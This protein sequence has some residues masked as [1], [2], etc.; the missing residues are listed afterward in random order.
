MAY[1]PN[2]PPSSVKYHYG[3][4]FITGKVDG[5]TV[6]SYTPKVDSGA[7]ALSG[8][9]TYKTGGTN[10][11]PYLSFNGTTDILLSAINSGIASA[12]TCFLV[13]RAFGSAGVF[14]DSAVVGARSGLEWKIGAPLDTGL[15]AFTVP[16]GLNSIGDGNGTWSGVGAD[17]I[18]IIQV[19]FDTSGSISINGVSVAA[20]DLTTT[21]LTRISLGASAGNFLA[22][23]HYDLILGVRISA[24]EK[25]DVLAYLF[26]KY[27]VTFASDFA[28]AGKNSGVP[29][30]QQDWQVNTVPSGSSPIS[31]ASIDFSG[32]TV[33]P[34]PLSLTT[35]TGYTTAATPATGT[36]S[37]TSTGGITQ[38][39]PR[40]LAYLLKTQAGIRIFWGNSLTR[41]F[42]ATTIRTTPSYVG[43]DYPSDVYRA[44]TKDTLFWY[45]RGVDSRTTTQMLSDYSALGSPTIQALVQAAVA[46]GQTVELIVWEGGN[47]LYLS[48]A[49]NAAAA[50]ANLVALKA[51][52]IADA[53]TATVWVCTVPDRADGGN[54]NSTTR[55]A[56]NAL[57]V[58]GQPKVIRYDNLG[59]VKTD[60][61]YYSTDQ[62]HFND[63]GYAVIAAAAS[64]AIDPT[65]PPPTLP[66]TGWIDIN[67]RQFHGF[68]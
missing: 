6:V 52:I 56:L 43:T 46:A 55:S 15:G 26:T 18:R 47:D 23:H 12:F 32:E 64:A 49:A 14:F 57:I 40:T 61:T 24:G 65:T 28:L 31:A 33:T 48:A 62:T 45:N 7:G 59:L 53:P 21:G 37:A 8:T 19:E 5:D 68:F 60:T 35:S 10:S 9:A 2:S 41:G 54:L 20:G 16:A 63:A 50:Y 13:A 34:D 44:S 27:G 4:S 1:D 25:T 42:N 22:H 30:M 39:T 58:A 66:I 51:L 67:N 3:A 38:P 36:L 11:M 29:N 17:S